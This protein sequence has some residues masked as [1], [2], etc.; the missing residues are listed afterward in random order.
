[1][2]TRSRDG[3]WSECGLLFVRP[4]AGYVDGEV[5]SEVQYTGVHQAMW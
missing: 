4:I 1:M 5:G 2:A 3:R